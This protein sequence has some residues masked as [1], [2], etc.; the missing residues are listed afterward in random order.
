MPVS[1][2][3]RWGNPFE[4]YGSFVNPCRLTLSVDSELAGLQAMKRISG[5]AA[6]TFTSNQTSSKSDID[7]SEII[8]ALRLAQD[9]ATIRHLTNPPVISGCIQLMRIVI[10]PGEEVSSPFS[11]EYGYLCFKLLTIVLNTCLFER[12]GKLD[13]MAARTAQCPLMEIDTIYSIMLSSGVLKLFQTIFNSGD[14][15]WILGWSDPT[16]SHQP[17]S[18]ISHSDLSALLRLLWD[19]RKLFMQLSRIDTSTQYELSGVFFLMWRFVTQYG[20]TEGHSDPN[21][22]TPKAMLYELSL[23]YMLVADECQRAAMF[24]VSANITCGPEW[25]ENAKHV[26]AEDSRFILTAFIQLLSNG[27]ISGLQPK[28]EPY[29]IL[30]LVPLCVDLDSQDL[31]PEVARC[32]LEYAWSVLIEQPSEAQFVIFFAPVFGCLYTLINPY[33]N[34]PRPTALSATTLL[35]LVRIMHEYDLLDFTA[36]AMV[37]LHT[38]RSDDYD[39]VTNLIKDAIFHF[40]GMLTDL[41]SKEQLEDCFIGYVPE[42]WKFNNY[43]FVAAYG[44]DNQ[45]ASDQKYYNL[46]MKIWHQIGTDLGLERAIDQYGSL[47]C[48][49]NRCPRAYLRGGVR[50]GCAGCGRKL[51]CGNWCQAIILPCS[52]AGI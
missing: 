16:N 7:I 6:Q 23:R 34:L 20:A 15:D 35:E 42:W 13:E 40:F 14:C 46:C 37:R 24:R 30:R 18:L 41:T 39:N 32:T 17:Q 43:L 47:Q 21:S 26:D 29:M 31:L 8:S 52:G 49:S 36:R 48:A 22:K 45:P 5:L 27:S 4:I 3:P 9:P 33:Y 38:T 51:Y 19:D 10:C 11:Y 2:H 1:S 28:Q 12:W 44:L 50:F 25:T